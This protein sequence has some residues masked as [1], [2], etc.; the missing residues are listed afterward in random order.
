MDYDNARPRLN[1]ELTLHNDMLHANN[2]FGEFTFQELPVD[3]QSAYDILGQI[4]GETTTRELINQWKAKIEPEDL[5]QLLDAMQEFGLVLKNNSAYMSGKAAM[6]EIEDEQ[7]AWLHAL[8]YKNPLWEALFQ[9]AAVPKNVYLGM[10]IETYHL[11]AHGAVF[12]SPALSFQGARQTRKEMSEVFCE[13]NGHYEI[14]L[15]ALMAEGFTKE[16][17]RNSVPLA[18]TKGLINALAFWS[19][20]DPLFFFSCMEIIEGKD[21]EVDTVVNA[22]ERSGKLSPEFVKKIKS[23]SLV[24]IEEGHASFGRRLLSGIDVVNPFD[25]ERAIR[26]TKLFVELYH[27]FYLAVWE[28]YSNEHNPVLR[29]I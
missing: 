16:E 6:L 27:H 28:Y 4:N 7:H 1:C 21:N 29:T 11:L 18:E 26:Q 19:A 3:S 17:I 8:L 15:S 14:F 13:E 2:E 20:N 10:A 9:P 22:M 25:V 5:V 12:D 24:N 23:H